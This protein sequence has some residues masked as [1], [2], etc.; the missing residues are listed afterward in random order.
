MFLLKENQFLE[1]PNYGN[2]SLK[3][4]VGLFDYSF[5]YSCKGQPSIPRGLRALR[6]FLKQPGEVRAAHTLTTA[7]P[8]QFLWG[9]AFRS[10]RTAVE[11]ILIFE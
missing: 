9:E 2:K 11:P 8:P 3:K 4:T 1:M 7:N 10:W 6:R 5:K